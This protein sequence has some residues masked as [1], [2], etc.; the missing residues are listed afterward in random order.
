MAELSAESVGLRLAALRAAYVPM[1]EAEA[2]PLLEPPP[3]VEDFAVAAARRLAELRALCVLTR[4]LQ[5][6]RR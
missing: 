2:R 6:R 3:R 5:R 4:Q 1:T